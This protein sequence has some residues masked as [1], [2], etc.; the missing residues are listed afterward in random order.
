MLIKL[1][2]K[3]F[4]ILFLFVALL[5]TVRGICSTTSTVCKMYLLDEGKDMSHCGSTEQSACRTLPY[6]LDAYYNY[7]R[8]L[9]VKVPLLNII[10]DDT[11]VVNKSLVVSSSKE[12]FIAHSHGKTEKCYWPQWESNPRQSDLYSWI[13][14]TEWADCKSS[15]A[16]QE[17]HWLSE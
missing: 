7:T 14:S 17:W 16:R 15:H 2:Y 12:F 1:S 10:T 3:R 6:V 8:P 13:C 11:L 9:N 4:S 5:N